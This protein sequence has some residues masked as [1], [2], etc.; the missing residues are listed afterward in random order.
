MNVQTSWEENVIINYSTTANR[1]SVQQ[2]KWEKKMFKRFFSF[3]TA[4]ENKKQS[5][6]ILNPQLLLY[7]I[8]LIFQ[9]LTFEKQRHVKGFLP[10]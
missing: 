7:I 4:N 9:Q 5:T 1:R 10:F 2:A 3:L 6:Y 8:I